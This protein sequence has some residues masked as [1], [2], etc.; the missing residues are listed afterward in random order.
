[1]G[2]VPHA[3]IL[4]QIHYKIHSDPGAVIVPSMIS[5][6]SSSNFPTNSRLNSYYPDI[7]AFPSAPSGRVTWRI[8]RDGTFSCTRF[9]VYSA[10]VQLDS[11]R[12]LR[13]EGRMNPGA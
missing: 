13:A 11:L 9:R 4:P 3:E 1:M 12:L 7:L 5:D 8:Y 2:A 6:H 10:H